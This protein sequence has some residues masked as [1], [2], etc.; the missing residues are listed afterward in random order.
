M[1]N[2][3]TIILAF[4]ALVAT[5]TAI[6][7]AQSGTVLWTDYDFRSIPEPKERKVGLYESAFNT[8]FIAPIKRGTDVPHW[9]RA[10]T[11]SPKQAS[12]VNAVDEVPD[13]SWFTNR[14]AL[15]HMTVQQLVRGPNRGTPPDFTTGTIT[16]AKLQ[17]VTPG[18]H[19][20]DASGQEYLV[21][22]DNK[23]YP[24]L[25][26]GAEVVSTK[27]LY[28][29]GYNVPENYI[30]FIT[31]DKL[32]IKDG[33]EITEGGKKHPFTHE[34]LAKMLKQVAKRPDGTYRV[35]ASKLLS[36]KPKGPFPYEGLRSDDPNDLIPHEHRRELR[37]L[38]VI[39]S[40]INHWDLKEMNTLDMYVEE[41]GRKFLR[42]YLIDFG[43][44]MGGGKSPTEY[45][46]GREYAFDKGNIFKEL[47]T[48]GLTVTPDEKS[49][50]ITYPEVGLFSATD[51]DPGDW[52][53]SFWVLPFSNMTRE[54]AL[55][56]TRIILSF[57]E[58][59][60]SNIVRTG[61]Y[62][63]PKAAE[64]ILKTLLE[65]R[66]QVATYWLKDQNPVAYFAVE[67]GT[68]GPELVFQ[69]LLTLHDLGLG[70]GE[71]R[72]EIARGEQWSQQ[73]ATKAPRIAL[74]SDFS[75]QMKIRIRTI[76][77]EKLSKPITLF[78]QN[79]PSGGYTIVQ[80]DRS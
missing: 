48:L 7:V 32:K 59:E 11:G 63:N 8:E 25:Q 54:D 6:T 5:T 4:I 53:P 10:A 31:P 80:I 73:Q 28:A 38:R 57:T 62:S 21:K 47:F 50:P 9:V 13:S 66:R 52:R 55:W 33:M 36:G 20:T 61:E 42:H 46:H 2:K 3:K 77:A 71:Y 67:K 78:V 56:A 60:L 41:G 14:H 26:S 22:F 43:S 64:Y 79:K 12:N 74:G 29:T 17:G 70:T 16:Q 23:N 68:T 34:D 1:R 35:L 49:P 58:D 40:W 27:I 69:D 18:L 51:F 45:F 65:R 30:A 39:A 75:G 15:R 76:R 37:G 19:L 24:E 44:S 72:Y